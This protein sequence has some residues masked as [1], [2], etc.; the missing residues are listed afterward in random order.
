LSALL[1][2]PGSQLRLVR[3]VIRY[4]PELERAVFYAC[5]ST[6][7]C[8]TLAAAKDLRYKKEM[9]VKTVTLDGTVIAKNGNMTG[10]T[11]GSG[12]P[13]LARVSRWDEKEARE[14]AARRD[15]LL[16]EEEALRRRSKRG[17]GADSSSLHVLIE[18]AE[19]LLKTNAIRHAG[20][21]K[22]VENTKKRIKES[23]AE[24]AAIASQIADHR[25]TFSE[26]TNRIEARKVELDKQQAKVRSCQ[27]WDAEQRPLIDALCRLSAL[28]CRYTGSQMRSLERSLR[29]SA[30]PPFATTRPLSSSARR[31]T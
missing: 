28:L 31:L 14:A 25:K 10:G 5:E 11:T 27:D 9:Y 2:K 26:L 21:A 16:S 17:H 30:S 6:V 7:L 12:D 22:E 4:E 3:D 19:T 8:D 13:D 24:S 1:S 29:V 18:D 15:A 23:A 20:L